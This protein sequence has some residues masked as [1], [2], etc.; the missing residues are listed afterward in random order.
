MKLLISY[1]KIMSSPLI[2][3]SINKRWLCYGGLSG[4]FKGGIHIEI[5]QRK[6][7]FLYSSTLQLS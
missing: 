1:L 6:I 4:S 2:F 3:G 7:Y 5:R